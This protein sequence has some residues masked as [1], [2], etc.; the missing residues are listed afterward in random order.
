MNSPSEGE[1]KKD[2]FPWRLKLQ[3][4]SGW[5]TPCVCRGSTRNVEDEESFEDLR[6]EA[7]EERCHCECRRDLRLRAHRSKVKV[8]VFSHGEISQVAEGSACSGGRVQLPLDQTR[9][10]I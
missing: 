4:I 1:R 10:E 9:E 7:Q 2:E 8:E 3:E 6:R 5:I